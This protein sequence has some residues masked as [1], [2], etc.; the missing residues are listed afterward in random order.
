MLLMLLLTW[1]LY[2]FFSTLLVYK[3]ETDVSFSFPEIV[4]ISSKSLLLE[5]LKFST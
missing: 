2:F 5:A 4:F 3:N 1:L